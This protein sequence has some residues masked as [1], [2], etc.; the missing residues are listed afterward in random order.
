MLLKVYSILNVLFDFQE[1]Y[2]PTS[3]LKM[4][5]Y[6]HLNLRL[7]CLAC[8]L[9]EFVA[10]GLVVYAGKP[11]NILNLNMKSSSVITFKLQLLY[12]WE[13]QHRIGK[14]RRHP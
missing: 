14:T 8:V 2:I 5:C 12:T 10:L 7:I 9:F 6:P 13:Y 11:I 1:N 4:M 3:Q